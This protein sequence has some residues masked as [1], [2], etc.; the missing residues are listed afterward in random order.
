MS[1]TISAA[2]GTSPIAALAASTIVSVAPEY[3]PISP[4]QNAP[5][6]EITKGVSGA[7]MESLT[8]AQV[9]ELDAYI[10]TQYAATGPAIT[11]TDYDGQPGGPITGGEHLGT[12]EIWSQVAAGASITG[13]TVATIV[14]TGTT[15]ETFVGTA[16]AAE[17]AAWAGANGGGGPGISAAP[18][19]SSV[20]SIAG[21]AAYLT[22]IFSG[23][24]PHTLKANLVTD[25]TNPDGSVTPVTTA[26][27]IEID[28]GTPANAPSAQAA[29]AAATAAFLAQLNGPAEGAGGTATTAAAPQPRAKPAGAAA[30][31]A[32]LSLSLR[33]LVVPATPIVPPV[34]HGPVSLVTGADAVFDVGSVTGDGATTLYGF[35]TS[36]ATVAGGFG[37]APGKAFSAQA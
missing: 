36:T 30:S 4:L 27:D 15:V 28:G 3:D 24:G 1:S 8:P 25:T 10:N 16:T 32:D 22:V 26:V 20:P 37:A 21:G 2:S 6:E 17:S 5:E 23:N 18:T 34:D 31:A 33:S 12:G 9:A 13:D 14:D 11:V 35:Y 7:V 29:A 19:V